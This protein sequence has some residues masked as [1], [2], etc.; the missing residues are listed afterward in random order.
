MG[1][2]LI[3]I[4]SLYGRSIKKS[5]EEMVLNL[6]RKC[7]YGRNVKWGSNT[8]PTFDNEWNECKLQEGV[9]K[10]YIILICL[11]N[12]QRRPTI[13]MPMWTTWFLKIWNNYSSIC[14]GNQVWLKYY[15][16]LLDTKL[17]IN[18]NDFFE[19]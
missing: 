13:P 19:Y 3:E 9:W 15:I 10:K 16:H 12:I 11:D 7:K 14:K 18:L 8:C 6:D 5:L 1:K 17:W 4:T 2:Y